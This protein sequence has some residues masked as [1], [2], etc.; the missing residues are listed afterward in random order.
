MYW[1]TVVFVI[2]FLRHASRQLQ[3]FLGKP[4]GH[5]AHETLHT[6][7]IDRGAVTI[8]AYTVLERERDV[9]AAD[10]KLGGL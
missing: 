5:K 7:Y 1:T 6:H 3:D 4:N 9:A 2:P 10:K 8:P